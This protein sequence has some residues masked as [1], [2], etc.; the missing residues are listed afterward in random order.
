MAVADTD[1]VDDLSK[2]STLDNGV[3][4]QRLQSGMYTVSAVH[5]HHLL[6]ARLSPAALAIGVHRLC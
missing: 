1:V 3:S 5:T 2:L 4:L 6:H